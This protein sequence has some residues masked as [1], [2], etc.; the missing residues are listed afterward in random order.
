MLSSPLL[1]PLPEHIPHV[2]GALLQHCVTHMGVYVGGG[3][4][5]AVAGNLHGDQR[6]DPGLVEQR[7]VVVPEI[8]RRDDGLDSK[9]I[10]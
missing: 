3:L 5:V 9:L 10:N 7:N 6:V 2:D 4:V 1:Y 8:M